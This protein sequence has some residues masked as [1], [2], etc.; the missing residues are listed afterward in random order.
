MKKLVLI[1]F[2]CTIAFA[3]PWQVTLEFANKTDWVQLKENVP[4]CEKVLQYFTKLNSTWK[5]YTQS[6]RS[7]SSMATSKVQAEVAMLK[8]RWDWS[9]PWREEYGGIQRTF[10][11]KDEPKSSYVVNLVP[12]SD[13]YMVNACITS[14]AQP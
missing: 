14:M 11:V 7:E 4:V 5:I 2:I 12:T 1:L 3:A 6:Y 8:L 10:T 9:S 13:T